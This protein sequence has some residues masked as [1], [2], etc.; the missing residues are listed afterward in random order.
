VTL[1]QL[2]RD[3]R[4]LEDVL[5]CTPELLGLQS[6]KSGVHGPFA[7]F[8][9]VSFSTPQGRQIIPDLL[10]LSSSGDLIIVEVKLFVNPELADR[11]VIAQA[12]DY[13][14][15]FSA[16]REAQLISIFGRNVP[17][18]STWAAV[19]QSLFPN[20]NDT[21]ELAEVLLSNIRAGNIHIIIA[22]D[23]A[24]RGLIEIV[25][26]VAAQSV[27]GFNM[28][29]LEATPYVKQDSEDSDILFVSFTRL[30]TEIVAR[31]AITLTYPAEGMKP[32]ISIEATNIE[33]IE[34]NISSVAEGET[35]RMG[36]RDWSDPE[37]EEAFLT[38]D[39]PTLR[40]LFLFAKTH[41]AGGRFKAPGLKKSAHFAFYVQGRKADGS[42]HTIQVFNCSA[43]YPRVVVFLNMTS[44]IAAPDVFEAYK[45]KLEAIFGS[46]IKPDAKE[47]NLPISLVSEH[48]EDFKEVVLWLQTTVNPN[49]RA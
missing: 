39:D 30:A 29:V 23:R 1:D 18:S 17:N 15:S 12:V 31:T 2:R 7:V 28:A 34:R 11:R 40:E 27:L 43:D 47:P 36:G 20:E 5:F 22:C 10:V 14:A 21:D 13:A 16:L 24:P 38:G 48:I 26:G 46:S 41:S 33:E 37:I 4:F 35:R 44:S 3:E 9:Q 32:V 45:K 42:A 25:R 49:A 19:I 8:R 6:R